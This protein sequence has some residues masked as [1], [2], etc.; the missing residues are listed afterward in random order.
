MNWSF[1]RIP[2]G[3]VGS[4][5]GDNLSSHFSIFLAFLHCPRCARSARGG[6]HQKRNP[7]GG[8]YITYNP[9]HKSPCS[10]L[11]GTEPTIFGWPPIS[12]LFRIPLFFGR[13]L[14]HASRAGFLPTLPCPLPSGNNSLTI[15]YNYSLTIYQQFPVLVCHLRCAELQAAL[16]PAEHR[17]E[18]LGQAL[19]AATNQCEE[20]ELKLTAV[21]QATSAISRVRQFINNFVNNLL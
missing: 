9:V 11:V 5:G 17:R 4:W 12:Q 13:P 15:C 3:T 2:V 14:L 10:F 1:F 16:A 20:L 18:Q 21:E 6:A 7:G 19:R 8:W